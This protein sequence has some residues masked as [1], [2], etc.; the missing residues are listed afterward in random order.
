MVYNFWQKRDF[1]EIPSDLSFSDQAGTAWDASD[2]NVFY[3]IIKLISKKKKW[4]KK[5]YFLNKSLALF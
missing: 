2:S 3:L 4:K 1:S 5:T